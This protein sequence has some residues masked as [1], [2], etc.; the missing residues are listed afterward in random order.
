[1][2]EASPRVFSTSFKVDL[3]ARLERGRAGREGCARERGCAQAHLRLA[4]VLIGRMGRPGSTASA[5]ARSG[6]GRRL[7]RS[8]QRTNSQRPRR[9]SPSSSGSSAA[10][11]RICIFFAK[12]CGS[13][14]RR[15]E[16]TARPPLRGHPRDDRRRA[17]RLFRKGRQHSASVRVGRR[18]ARRLLPRIS[19]PHLRSATTSTCATSSSVSRSTNRHYGY[20]RIAHELQAPGL[21]RQ[22]QAGAAAD[23]ARTTCS[24]S[25]ARPFIPHHDDEPAWVLRS[26]PN[27]TRGLVPTGLDQIWVADIT[28]VRLAGGLRLSG[29]RPRRLL[30]QG[31]RLGARRSSRGEPGDRGARHGARR[32]RSGARE[33]HPPLGPR[34]AIRLR[35]PI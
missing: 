2:S 1:M 27:L 29:G 25:G 9:G 10:N 22:H 16:A 32:P 14:T 26:S 5:A 28:Y 13:G 18:V 30:A 12:P 11:R 21:D 33:P 24:L 34:R 19:R 35:S 3:V 4:E 8:P 17:A 6:G 31:D 15:A 23:C 20:R 7:P